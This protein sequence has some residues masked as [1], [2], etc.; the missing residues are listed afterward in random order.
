MYSCRGIGAAIGPILVKK[1]FG[2]STKTLQQAII[3][4][5]FLGSFALWAFSFTENLWTASLCIGV[6][7]MFGSI[8]WVFSSSLIHLEA[9]KQ[10]LG[11]I[12]GTEMAL[13]TLIM[14]LSNGVVGVA[15][16][17]LHMTIESVVLWMSCLF[18]IPGVLWVLFLSSARS[19][20]RGGGVNTSL[21]LAE[22]DDI[23][24]SFAIPPNKE[25]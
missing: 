4:A 25:P 2:E 16:D 20:F 1:W 12:F 11:R 9:D 17:S 3:A 14:G 22:L 21:T 18:F 8:I 19:E 10:Y 15:I 23:N 6:S 24:P 7:G 13:L 5:F